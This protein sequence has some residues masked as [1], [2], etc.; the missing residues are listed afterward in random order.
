MESL[1]QNKKY[2]EFHRA[3]IRVMKELAK[4]DLE[5]WECIEVLCCVKEWLHEQAKNFEN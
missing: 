1:E 3:G 5:V 2:K 4:T